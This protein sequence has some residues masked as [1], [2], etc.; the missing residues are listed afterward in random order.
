[1]QE[2]KTF[3]KFIDLTQLFNWSV[4]GLLDAKFS[5]SKKYDLAKIG[6]FLIKSRQVVNI[7]DEK[8]YKRV[9]V[10]INNNGV[11]LR[12]TEKGVNIGTKKQ[13]LASAGQ[14]IVS[15][16]DARNGA[17][18]IIPAD[19]DGAVVTNDF[20]VFNVNTKKILPQF[21]LLVTTT[22]H[23]IKFAQS[24]SSGTTNR[25]RMDIEMFLEQRIPLPTLKD[26][27]QILRE[28]NDKLE[29][30]ELL[31]SKANKLEKEIDEF[32]YS[33]LDLRKLTPIAKGVRFQ[34]IEYVDLIEWG[35]DK[36]KAGRE[37]EQG[38]FPYTSIDENPNLALDIYRGKSPVYVEKSKKFILNQKCNRWN[39]ID[40]TYVKYVDET[41][42]NS[43]ENTFF[44]KEG[45]IIINST[46]EGTIGRASYINKNMSGLIYDSHILLLRL[47][48]QLVNP[49][50]FVEV[51]NSEIGQKQVNYLKSAQATKQTELGI[52]NLRRIKIPLPPSISQQIKIVENISAK[53][54]L[55]TTM[56]AE[57]NDLI[58]SAI[59]EFEKSIFEK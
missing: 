42:Y 46:G 50:Y 17:F 44:T 23:F 10:R 37:Y 35:I 15:K 33:S 54:K 41:W 47:N 28:Y 13:Y 24:C 43:I 45:D 12:D 31:L 51:F 20:P 48:S 30:G 25:Q 4:Q 18:G 55:I 29:K 49:Q 3:L 22:K 40:L 9:T 16:I 21:L 19:L 58:K 53:R 6:D 52:N 38:R 39:N 59:A 11:L 27:E 8:S 5:Y 14:F 56:I 7:E 26:Q 1:M 2:E 57:R 36:I 32:L 34:L